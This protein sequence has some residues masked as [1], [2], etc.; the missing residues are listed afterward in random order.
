MRRGGSATHRRGTASRGTGSRARPG[1]RGSSRRRRPGSRRKRSGSTPCRCTRSH[2]EE[3]E[4][5]GMRGVSSRTV[6]REEVERGG[7][8]TRGGGAGSLALGAGTGSTATRRLGREDVLAVRHGVERAAV[9]R[10][11]ASRGSDSDAAVGA[12]RGEAR[13]ALARRELTVV[14]ERVGRRAVR[15]GHAGV[16]RGVGAGR[17]SARALGV[18]A[19]RA[20]S[21][22]ALQEIEDVGSQRRRAPRGRRRSCRGVQ[23]G[24]PTRRRRA[25]GC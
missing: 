14:D 15:V 4:E 3:R 22:R 7:R 9:A 6:R 10:A 12:V 20:S 8:R 1:W 13:R 5:G 11:S 2:L 17:A 24:K 25:G 23:E 19:D 18:A 21:R 16:G